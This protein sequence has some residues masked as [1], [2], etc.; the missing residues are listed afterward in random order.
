MYLIVLFGCYIILMNLILTPVA[1]LL[2]ILNFVYICVCVCVCVCMR[3]CLS[4]C[5]WWFCICVYTYSFLFVSL[6]QLM[7]MSYVDSISNTLCYTDI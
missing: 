3:A 2:I 1:N 7:F 4:V 5:V 6:L